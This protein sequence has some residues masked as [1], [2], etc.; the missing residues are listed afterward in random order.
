MLNPNFQQRLAKVSGHNGL[1]VG[2][3]FPMQRCALVK[4]AHG[5]SVAGISG[6]ADYGAYSIVVGG[7]AYKDVDEE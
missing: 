4:G 7:G 6:S 3:W 1:A 2:A 5:M